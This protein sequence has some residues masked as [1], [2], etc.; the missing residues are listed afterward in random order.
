MALKVFIL[1]RPGSGK[2]TAFRHIKK[3][4]EEQYLDWSS[5][6]FN[7]YD[8]LREMFLFE[9]LFQTDMKLRKFRATEHGGFDVLDFSVLDTALRELERKVR[10][11]YSPKR[12]ELIVIEFARDNYGKA[13]QQFS[14]AF[15]KDAYF[16]FIETNMETCVQRVHDRVAHPMTIDDHFV[17]DDILTS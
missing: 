12:D 4:I 16:L 14:S 2:S 3:Y 6:R 10:H 1:G 11:R 13:L 15:L 17:S 7:D 8:I 9:K 5:I